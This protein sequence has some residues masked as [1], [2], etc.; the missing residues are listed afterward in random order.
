[1]IEAVC[2][3]CGNVSSYDKKSLKGS[4]WV[5]NG[6]DTI[7]CIPC[8]DEL[9]QKIAKGRGLK[10]RYGDGGDIHKISVRKGIIVERY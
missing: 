7:L 4:T 10:I 6:M 2:S 9:L 5:I 3:V 8:E 1:M